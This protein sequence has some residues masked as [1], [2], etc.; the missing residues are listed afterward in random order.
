MAKT[1]KKIDPEGIKD[2]YRR[3]GF[4]AKEPFVAN[5]ADRLQMSK[6]NIRR[7]IRIERWK[8]I[9]LESIEDYF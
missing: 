3:L 2:Y 7:K 1:N 6:G 9:E 8:D 5:L 4:G